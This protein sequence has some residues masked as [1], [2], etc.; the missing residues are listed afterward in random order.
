M[1]DGKISGADPVTPATIYWQQ[2]PTSGRK[3]L[4]ARR[5]ITPDP[6]L[7]KG[8]AGF[9]HNALLVYQNRLAK[10][11]DAMPLTCNHVTAPVA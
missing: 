8:E 3:S 9:R 4:W 10:R 1:N 2:P 6:D 11:T 5:R 7:A